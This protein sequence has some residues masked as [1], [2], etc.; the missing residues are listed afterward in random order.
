M[1]LK[2]KIQGKHS[3]HPRIWTSDNQL[4]P[5]VKKTLERIAE[6]FYQY[7]DIEFPVIDLVIT[8]SMANYNWT[9]Q[10]DLDLHL[11][12]DYKQ[13]DCDQELAELFDTKRRLYELE[14]KISVYNI[15][16]TLYVED[17]NQPG[18]SQGVYSVWDNQWIKL[19]Q[20]ITAEIDQSKFKQD[21]TMWTTLIKSAKKSKNLTLIDN[22][23]KL[24]R[25]YRRQALKQRQGEFSTENLVYKQL[26]NQGDLGQLQDLANTLKTQSLSLPR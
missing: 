8:G 4:K 22:L 1:K 20:K 7:C 24:L 18:V 13:I 26:R 2:N 3:L 23:L 25:Q 10:S 14:H 16:V 6:D 5:E 12:T 15:P 17:I 9:P 11:I 19:P 21:L